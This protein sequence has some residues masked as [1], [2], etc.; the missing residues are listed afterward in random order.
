MDFAEKRCRLCGCYVTIPTMFRD[1][2]LQLNLPA[3]QRHI[4]FL[5]D[6]GIKEG[7]GVILAGGAAGDL[8][9]DEI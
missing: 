2:D 9:D 7:T 8:L 5:F 1:D 3:M 4:E 6:G